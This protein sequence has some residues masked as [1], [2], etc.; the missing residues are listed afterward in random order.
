MK[1]GCRVAAA[2]PFR[3]SAVNRR[4][5][6]MSFFGKIEKVQGMIKS[7]LIS[8]LLAAI[9]GGT[10]NQKVILIIGLA[11]VVYSVYSLLTQMWQPFLIGAVGG[12]IVYFALADYERMAGKRP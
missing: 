3:T 10:L 1:G 4:V 11:V 6:S 8:R 2:P 7:A 12:V 5:E 9:L